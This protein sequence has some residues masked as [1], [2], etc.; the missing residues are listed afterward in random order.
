LNNS[1]IP[2]IS[3]PLKAWITSV[4]VGPLVVFSPLA[5]HHGLVSGRLDIFSL[6]FLPIYGLYIFIGATISA[7]CFLIL[8]IC[9]RLI[10]RWKWNTMQ[11]KVSL[12]LTSLICCLTI[13]L[14]STWVDSSCIWNPDNLRLIVAYSVPLA[15]S[16]LVYNPQKTRP[17]NIEID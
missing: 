7:P 1:S 8:W 11:I 15:F 4:L 16:V 5:T 13:F 6:D 9:Y 12:L 2:I 14:V 10:L 17:Y 3:F